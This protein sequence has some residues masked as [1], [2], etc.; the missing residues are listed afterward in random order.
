[1]VHVFVKMCTV[2]IHKKRTT[3][4][5]RGND[6]RKRAAEMC[7]ISATRFLCIV[8]NKEYTNGKQGL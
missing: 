1:M 4:K 7:I 8:D 6:I 3:K 2:Y 5:R